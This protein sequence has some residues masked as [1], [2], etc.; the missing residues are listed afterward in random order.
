MTGNKGVML[1]FIGL[2]EARN[3][4]HVTQQLK[5]LLPPCEQLVCVAL[6]TDIEHQP[7]AA[8]VIYAV[9]GDGQLHRPEI[10]CQMTACAADGVDEF[11]AYFPAQSGQ[12]ILRKLFQVVRI[13]YIA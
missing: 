12:F 6:V 8:G 4:A 3:A 5:R 11:F 7:V 10:G 9:N 2:R 1:G 13:F